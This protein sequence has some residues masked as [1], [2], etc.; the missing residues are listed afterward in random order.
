MSS[1][2]HKFLDCP[3]MA[4]CYPVVSFFPRLLIPS[5]PLLFHPL[6]VRTYSLIPMKEFCF[7]SID[8]VMEPIQFPD[9]HSFPACYGRL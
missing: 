7:E 4:L 1:L 3:L 2:A 9:P 6:Y 8:L 5:S